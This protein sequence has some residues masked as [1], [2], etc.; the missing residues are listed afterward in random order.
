[1]RLRTFCL[2][3]LL[4]V[5]LVG[6]TQESEILRQRVAVIE[7]ERLWQ[8]HPGYARLAELDLQLTGLEA[9]RRELLGLA[10]QN[11]DSLAL[12]EQ[13]RQLWEAQ[14]MEMRQ[15]VDRVSKEFQ[16]RTQQEMASIHARF[17]GQLAEIVKK[18]QIPSAEMLSMAVTRFRL[19]KQKNLEHRLQAELQRRSVDLA[20]QDD[21]AASQVQPEKV[22]LQLALQVQE[23]EQARR[24]LQ[25]L[26]E[27]L[28]SEREARHQATMREFETWADEQRSGLQREV[29]NYQLRLSGQG[30]T[31]VKEF[32]AV[33]EA[34]RQE[35]QRA[36]KLRRTEL[37]EVVRRLESAGRLQFEQRLSQL[38]SS[39]WPAGE[40]LPQRFLA[41]AEAAR[42]RQ[43]PARIQAARELRRREEARLSRGIA[44][45][46]GEQAQ[47]RGFEVV[48]T[49]LR[50]SSRLQDLTDV[51]LA[52]VSQLR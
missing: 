20:Q 15:Q 22:N 10:R 46:V 38:Q 45:V 52:G 32:L 6:A 36:Q 50:Y 2:L 11:C 47:A 28:A 19:E 5:W 41:P 42:L 13:A 51:C 44:Q 14:Q 34:E 29:A 9:Q 31:P 48:L 39:H 3:P 1:M 16:G 7:R 26:D 8:C 30:Q 4:G 17:E 24:R 27:R 25:E 21:Q 18:S 12:R 37:V 23:N 33:R 35:L 40:L 43:L 49:D